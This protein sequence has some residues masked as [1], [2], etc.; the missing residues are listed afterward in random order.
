MARFHKCDGCPFRNKTAYDKFAP[1]D[2]CSLGSDLIE[3][4]KFYN[5]EECPFTPGRTMTSAREN[6]KIEIGAI[7]ADL[8]QKLNDTIEALEKL[9]SIFGVDQ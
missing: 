3:A 8:S 7:C 9:K 2:L 1:F 6:A 4:E 5:A